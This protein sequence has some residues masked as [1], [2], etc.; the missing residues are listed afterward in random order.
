[1]SSNT[2]I[3]ALA[4]AL[5]GIVG[6]MGPSLSD[7]S[8]KP[9]EGYPHSFEQNE[10][11]VGMFHVA[12][13][14][15]DIGDPEAVRRHAAL[16]WIWAGLLRAELPKS[17]RMSC[18]GWVV[19]LGF[20]GIR[21]A[22][23]ASQ[24]FGRASRNDAH[25]VNALETLLQK[26]EPG[27]ELI[28]HWTRFA[29]MIDQPFRSD[30]APARSKAMHDARA[31]LVSAWSE[32]Y[33]KGSLLHSLATVDY[34]AIAKV[35]PADFRAWMTSQRRPERRLLEPIP[36]C[37][38]LPRNLPPSER[39]P[40]KRPESGILPPGEINLSRTAIAR[41]VAGPL[42]HAVIIGAPDGPPTLA[43]VS[44]VEAKY[45]GREHT[46]EVGE[47]ASSPMTITVRLRCDHLTLS[48]LDLWN[49]I[50]CE[51]AECVSEHVERAVAAAIT[52]DPEILEF[53][54]LGA[55]GPTPRG[56]YLVTVR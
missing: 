45:C 56:P 47:D 40:P 46:F 31:I 52:K 5:I 38:P 29:A 16:S 50:Y 2:L 6:T 9:R 12:L 49:V 27:D 51:P 30:D 20:P 37:F 35:E 21:A 34:A 55:N 14:A 54:R 11:L 19:D 43:V 4:F 32:I 48:D 33:V 3:K 25:C 23:K 8:C 44:E 13:Q 53:V 1:M 15:P 22:V 41:L 18:A 39:I 28:K 24:A 26:F 42:R 10:H 36:H 17:T 7:D